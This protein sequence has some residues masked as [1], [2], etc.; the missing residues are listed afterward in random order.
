MT[1]KELIKALED[2]GVED[3]EVIIC[4][5]FSGGWD[6]IEK[7]GYIDGT[8]AIIFGGGNPFSDE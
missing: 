3:Y 5:D 7:I 2:A 8:P 6:N 1:K 4:A